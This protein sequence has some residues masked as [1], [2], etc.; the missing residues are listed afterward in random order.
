MWD[1]HYQS[2]FTP[3]DTGRPEPALLAEIAAGG[4]PPGRALEIG[5]G[6]GT[7]AR[8]LA[9]AGWDVLGVDLAPTAIAQAR[10]AG[11][12]RFEVLDVLADAPPGGPYDLVFDR[13][14]F[15]VFDD[16]A[17]RDR[18]A[19]RVA[20]ALRPEG[21]WLSLVGSTEGGPRAG[22]PPRRSA[23]DVADAIEPHL[24]V[25]SLRRHRFEDSSDATAWILRARR[26]TVDAAPSTRR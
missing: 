9:A 17:D 12:A 24:E 11:G 25:L 19:A 26:R 5:C 22:G 3:W 2:G 13:G 10:A 14:C 7:N 23:R 20:A 16:P 8:A 4:L 21:V 18:F 15:H 1:Q 6:T